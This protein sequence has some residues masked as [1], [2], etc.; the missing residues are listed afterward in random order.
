MSETSKLVISLRHLLHELDSTQGEPTVVMKDNQGAIVWST[1][2]VRH[3]KHV[4]IRRNFSKEQI[5]RGII[6]A[7]YC[8]TAD[9]TTDVLTKPLLRHAFEKH[10]LSLGVRSTFEESSE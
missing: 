1:E 3:A 6:K 2:G 9:M 8:P 5:D 4:P 10:R 7:Q